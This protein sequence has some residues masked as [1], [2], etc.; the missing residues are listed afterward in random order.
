MLVYQHTGRVVYTE[1][2]ILQTEVQTNIQSDLFRL[3]TNQTM[4][5]NVLRDDAYTP[6]GHDEW[7]ERGELGSE[8]KRSHLGQS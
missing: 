7:G 8:A 5:R 1:V 6:E 4:S 3:Y 2:S